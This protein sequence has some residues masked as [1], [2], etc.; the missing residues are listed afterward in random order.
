[1]ATSASLQSEIELKEDSPDAFA[2]FAY[3]L[4]K[5]VLPHESNLDL[6]QYLQVFVFADKFSIPGLAIL[7]YEVLRDLLDTGFLL[8]SL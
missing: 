7:T 1:M 4:Y 6:E 8:W 5:G 3:W 2:V